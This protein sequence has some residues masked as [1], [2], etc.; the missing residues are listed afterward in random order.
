MS[1]YLTIRE[2]CQQHNPAIDADSLFGWLTAD[3]SGERYYSYN[4][5]PNPDYAATLGADMYLVHT[6]VIPDLL[7][8]YMEYSNLFVEGE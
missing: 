3:S 8:D 1:Q 5:T 7:S 2:A 6:D 4:F